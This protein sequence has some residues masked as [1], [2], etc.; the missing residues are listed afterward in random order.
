MQSSDAIAPFAATGRGSLGPSVPSQPLRP[1]SLL[2]D[3]RQILLGQ[4]AALLSLAERI[5]Q[6]FA[7]AVQL[8][9]SRKGRVVVCGIGKSGLV[10]RKMAATLSSTGTPSFF[11]HASE[12]LHGDLGMVT[13]DDTVIMI[14]N[15][16]KTKEILSI[17]PALR[18]MNVPVIAMCGGGELE[19]VATVSLSVGV[20]REACPLNLAPTTSTLVTLAMGDALAISLSQAR[21]FRVDDFARCH[22][23]GELGRRYYSRVQD[24]MRSQDLPIVRPD[25]PMREVLVSITQGRCGLAIVEGEAREL[26]G[27]ITDGDLRRALQRE[28]NVL[29]LQAR[30]IMTENPLIIEQSA[31]VEEAESMMERR[32]VK[33]L[34]AVDEARHVSGVIEFFAT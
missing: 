9:L 29:E 1:Q 34:L 8:I 7:D 2:S 6:S 19:R 25:L 11:L 22:P 10:G 15:S 14:S 5:D 4:S 21:G 28:P 26:L 16:G 33:A 30:D 24:A 27:I 12:A 31:L 20:D 3:A 23:G 13:A 17:V 18:Q 32:K